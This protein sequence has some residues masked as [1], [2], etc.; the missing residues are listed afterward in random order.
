MGLFRKSEQVDLAEALPKTSGFVSVDEQNGIENALAPVGRHEF[1]NAKRR[2]WEENARLSAEVEI[3]KRRVA[4]L[5]AHFKL[6]VE[7]VP[8]VPAHDR[9]IE[10]KVAKR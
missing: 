1:S 6:E 4:Q 7:K 8:E 2:L 10:T 5:L 3:L 9:L